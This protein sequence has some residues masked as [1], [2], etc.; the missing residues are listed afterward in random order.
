M[1][2]G[3]KWSGLNALGG[4]FLDCTRQI[5]LLKRSVC[6]KISKNHFHFT[7]VAIYFEMVTKI[8]HCFLLSI[9]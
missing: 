8:F 3:D 5:L 4:R 1:V 6:V 7:V 9:D 2:G